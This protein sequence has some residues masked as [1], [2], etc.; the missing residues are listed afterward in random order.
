MDWTIVALT[1]ML[2]LTIGITTALILRLRGMRKENALLRDHGAAC[3]ATIAE[4]EASQDSSVPPE[5]WMADKIANLD[6]KDPYHA[7]TKLFF[8]HAAAAKPLDEFEA[9][10]LDCIAQAGLV[11]EPTESFED[12]DLKSLLQKFTQDSR[13]MMTCIQNLEEENE[14]LREQL[15]NLESAQEA[16]HTTSSDSESETITD[17]GEV[18]RKDAEEPQQSNQ[19][20]AA[21]VA[22]QQPDVSDLRAEIEAE[23]SIDTTVDQN[24]DQ[25]IDQSLDTQTPPPASNPTAAPPA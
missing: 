24:S 7:L 15:A 3:N 10:V 19:E 22:A 20:Q 18:P 2:V 25:T 14:S 5:Q 1:Q 13:E 6:T 16:A 21:N 4:L 17:P 11:P 12:E 9:A 8:E 23:L